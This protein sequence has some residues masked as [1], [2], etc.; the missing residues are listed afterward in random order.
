MTATQTHRHRSRGS[1]LEPTETFPSNVIHSV[2]TKQN[3]PSKCSKT[4]TIPYRLPPHTLRTCSDTAYEQD[5]QRRSVPPWRVPRGPAAPGLPLPRC[6]PLPRSAVLRRGAAGRP[7]ELAPCRKRAPAGRPS[8][9]RA[10]TGAPRSA[11]GLGPGC[12]QRLTHSAQPLF[13]VSTPTQP[14]RQAA[15][16]SPCRRACFRMIPASDNLPAILTRFTK[17]G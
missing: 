5:T 1:S 17:T 11:A 7:G 4:R 2:S 14:P 6:P 12:P 10:D 16:P 9:D 8:V 3:G 13:P 15:W